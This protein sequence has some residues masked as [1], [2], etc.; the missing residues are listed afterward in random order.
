VPALGA[1]VA[2]SDI[3]AAPVLAGML[4]GVVVALAGHIVRDRRIVAVGIAALF[5]ATAVLFVSAFA[6]FQGDDQAGPTACPPGVS[7]R[8]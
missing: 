4:L 1:L 3:P 8:C 2:A 7:G 5:L 6:A